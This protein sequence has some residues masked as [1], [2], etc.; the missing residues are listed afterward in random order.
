VEFT[1]TFKKP[2]IYSGRIEI[3]ETAGNDLMDMDNYYYFR[4]EVKP[5]INVLVVDGN[6]GYTL[7]GGESY[8]F[9]KALSP[10]NYETPV[11]A[12]IINPDELTSRNLN[13][14]DVLILLNTKLTEDI[15]KKTHE[16]SLRRGGVGIFLGDNTDKKMYNRLLSSIMPVEI[17][18][19]RP[20]KMGKDIKL[21]VSDRFN[22]IFTETYK[23]NL[24]A[25]YKTGA[26]PEETPDIYAGDVP[27]L[28]L[29]SRGQ[30][31]RGRVA[32]FTSTADMDWTDF[33]VKSAYPA[34]INEIVYFLSGIKNGNENY[35]VVGDVLPY[36]RLK[37]GSVNIETKQVSASD[38][39]FNEL[40]GTRMPANYIIGN[41]NDRKVF[42]VNLRLKEGHV[43][44]QITL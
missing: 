33:P 40:P 12:R 25:I 42:S 2:G 18:S 4:A 39:V 43:C 37:K 8:F 36:D 22:E 6:P 11:S 41:G 14:Y 32:L 7:M 17:S 30:S 19:N 26:S 21:S 3:E 15:I 38:D 29:Y 13:K 27:L 28:W 24:A 20:E 35:M 1:Y 10:R 5:K 16:F 44:R 34:F 31:D 9:A 23:I